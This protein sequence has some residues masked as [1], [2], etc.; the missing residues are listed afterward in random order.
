MLIKRLSY[1]L[2][3]GLLVSCFFS[4]SNKKYVYLKEEKR[5]HEDTGKYALRYPEYK[6]QSGD[7]L[8]IQFHSTMTDVEEMFRFT[9]GE[10]S[11][12]NIANAGRSGGQGAFFYGYMINDSGAVRIPVIGNIQ[13]EGLDLEEV[14]KLVEEEARKYV[15]DVIVKVRLY[16][17]RITLL[18]EFNNTGTHFIYKDRVHILDA[19]AAGEDLTYFSDRRYLRIIR[20]TED[21]MYTYSIDLTDK[22]L[23]TSEKFY[24]LPNDIVYAEPSSRKIFRE[25]ISDYLLGITTLSSTLAL[26][27]VLVKK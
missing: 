3:Y 11:A 12:S 10:M 19:V 14:Q 26:I 8:D 9:G 7:F 24:L 13:L 17:I 18:G 6:L 5:A 21:N 23:L 2:F 15:N 27:V 20:E 22:D 4:C 1:I 16:G 25:T